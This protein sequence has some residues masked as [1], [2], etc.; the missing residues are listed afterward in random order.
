MPGYLYSLKR[1]Y[2]EMNHRKQ[3]VGL[4]LITTQIVPLLYPLGSELTVLSYCLV[5]KELTHGLGW[6]AGNTFLLFFF[7][8]QGSSHLLAH[9]CL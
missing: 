7:F 3:K 1:A 4:D 9:P 6:E 2:E 5:G 8:F